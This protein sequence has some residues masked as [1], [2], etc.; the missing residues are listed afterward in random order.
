MKIDFN[1]SCQEAKFLRGVVTS[2]TG[3]RQ[4]ISTNEINLMDAGWNASA[5]RYTGG[6]ILVANLPGVDIGSTIEVEYEITTKGK[7]FL[8]G[9]ESFQLPDDVAKK[10]FV[11]TAP[12]SVKI[13]TLR[14]GD[15]G[16]IRESRDTSGGSGTWQWLGENAK[17]LPTETMLPPAWN[18]SPCVLYYAGDL[19]SYLNDLNGAM[20]EHSH[21]R[22]KAAEMAAQLTSS[23]KTRR[24]AVQAIRDFVAKSIRL[25][26]PSF[27][28]LPLTELSD[29]DTTL[30]EGYGH[31]ADR[32][33]LLHAM[34]AAAGFQPEF[35]EASFYP[36]IAGITNVALSF[37]MPDAYAAPL[38]KVQVEGENYYLN[39]TDQYARL[40]S[41]SYDGRLGFVLSSQTS[42]LIQAAKDCE[43][44]TDTAY[45][46]TVSDNGKTRIGVTRHY[47]GGELRRGESLFLRTAAG[48]K[49]ALL[50][51]NGFRHGP[52]SAARRRSDYPIRHLSR[53]GAI[54]RGH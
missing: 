45:T 35:V 14:T 1:P 10:S 13:Q 38:V 19:R 17:A 2:K 43:N 50:S 53:P 12:D 6:K 33:I 47:Y 36:P 16:Q 28:E 51:G 42:E 3:E 41:T 29:A 4:E 21:K 27:T 11:L 24:E 18:Y 25:A 48:G 7:P 31:A 8:S 32:A 15:A 23:G 26:G 22:A 52:G 44:K 20:L 37:P 39:D 49:A 30:A 5:K 9:L 54:H 40:G 46:L 34:L